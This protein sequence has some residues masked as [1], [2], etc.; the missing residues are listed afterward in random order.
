MNSFARWWQLMSWFMR[1]R[2]DVYPRGQTGWRE[3]QAVKISPRFFE[4]ARVAEHT[5]WV[6]LQELAQLLRDVF[7]AR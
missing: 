1:N 3:P 6:R 4:E 2:N 5:P 7:A